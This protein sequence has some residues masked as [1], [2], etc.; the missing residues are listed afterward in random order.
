M[1]PTFAPPARSPKSKSALKVSP[2]TTKRRQESLFGCPMSRLFCETG[3]FWLLLLITPLS[4]F[5][6]NPDHIPARI[7]K[8][9]RN[10]PRIPANP[11]HNLAAI[12]HD[13]L[14]RR[15]RVLHPD[16]NHQPRHR[17]RRT[18]QH[19]R[20]AHFSHRI[21]KRSRAGPALPHFPSK[22]FVVEVGRA[23]DVRGRNFQITNI[24][25]SECR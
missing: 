17:A 1:K 23:R 4:R 14:H 16:V 13:R 8:P 7:T 10:L 21:V 2:S 11:L 3:G 6:I 15:R 9:C 22:Y 19:K 5:L 18:P 25:V 20:P 12:R 24:A